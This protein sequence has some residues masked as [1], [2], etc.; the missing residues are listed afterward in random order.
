MNA[1]SSI[2]SPLRR[3][4]AELRSGDLSAAELRAT[5]ERRVELLEGLG[6]SRR[7]ALDLLASRLA[8]LA[9]RASNREIAE[10][11]ADVYFEA[12]GTGQ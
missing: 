2:L 4:R 3:R 8:P 1:T 7:E 12:L 11:A 9:G 5:L 10:A 6:L